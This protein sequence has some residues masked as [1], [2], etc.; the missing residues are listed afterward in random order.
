MR[1][2]SAFFVSDLRLSSIRSSRSMVLAGNTLFS[3][4]RV[5]SD[6]LPFDRTCTN[7]S[8]VS[9][10]RA[11]EISRDAECSVCGFNALVY[12]GAMNCRGDVECGRVACWS[13]ALIINA[14]NNVAIKS[15][16]NS[17]CFYKRVPRVSAPRRARMPREARNRCCRSCS[18]ALEIVSRARQGLSISAFFNARLILSPQPGSLRDFGAL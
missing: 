18:L 15:A 4:I 16:P 14:C 6:T 13:R 17:G 8:V 12:R 11:Q 2:F 5:S 7:S 9:P 3:R 1:A 10:A